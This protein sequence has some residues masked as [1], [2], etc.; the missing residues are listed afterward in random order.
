MIFDVIGTP[1]ADDIAAIASAK[2]RNYLKSLP[3]K[4]RMSFAARYPGADAKTLEQSVTTPLEQQISGV[5]N[6]AYMSSTS[7]NNAAASLNCPRSSR[8]FAVL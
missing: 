7:S 5:D 2:A 1:T 8:Y 4:K 6:M 3:P